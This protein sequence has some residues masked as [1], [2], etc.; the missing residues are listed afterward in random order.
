MNQKEFFYKSSFLRR[1]DILSNG[2]FFC[3]L[4][5]LLLLSFL[6]TGCLKLGL[7]SWQKAYWFEFQSPVVIHQIAIRNGVRKDLKPFAGPRGTKILAGIDYCF[8]YWASPTLTASPK[9]PAPYRHQ[10]QMYLSQVC[11]KST[12]DIFKRKLTLFCSFLLQRS[13][14]KA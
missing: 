11:M 2:W 6:P 10:Q 13:F 12:Q 5:T 4:E 3:L 9:N 14:Q 1:F 7:H 8:R